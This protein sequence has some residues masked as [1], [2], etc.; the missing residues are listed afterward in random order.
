MYHKLISISLLCACA[1]TARGEEI[2]TVGQ[3]MPMIHINIDFNSYAAPASALTV[4]VDNSVPEMQPLSTLS[5][6]SSFN[7]SDPWYATL[8]PSQEGLAWTRQYGFVTTF[9]PAPEGL[10]F[11]VDM[12]VSGS[13]LEAYYVRDS[14][15][16]EFT[17]IFGT[18]GSS[19]Q[20]MYPDTM[21]HPVFAADPTVASY[22]VSGTIYLGDIDGIADSS[23]TAQSFTLD[24]TAV[25]EPSTY[26]LGGGLL[27]LSLLSLR[28][29]KPTR[30]DA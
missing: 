13:G 26:A 27:A 10:Y 30:T 15:P 11:W 1:L 12:D 4:I 14:S 28:R 19:T 9:D 25:P 3:K 5:P 16:T 20:W 24:F 22:S 7:P 18:D 2:N 6:G 29:L 21:T 23:Y 8:D 17:A